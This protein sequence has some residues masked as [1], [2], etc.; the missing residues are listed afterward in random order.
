MQKAFEKEFA[1]AAN[2]KWST[3]EDYIKVDFIFNNVPLIACYNMVGENLA[4]M[5]NIQFLSLPLVLQFNLQ[6]NY[7]NYGITR[8]FE[9]V[10]KEGTQYYLTLEKDDSYIQ[11]HSYE[12]SEWEVLEKK[13]KK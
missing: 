5:R 12:N 1:G 9:L 13:Q 4:V 7:K 2:V 6:K 8:L 3:Y 10:N 11:L